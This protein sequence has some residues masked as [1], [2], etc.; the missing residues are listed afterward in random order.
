MRIFINDILVP[1]GNDELNIT[2]KSSLFNEQDGSTIYNFTL[3]ASDEL[4]KACGFVNRL[5]AGRPHEVNFKLQQDSFILIGIGLIIKFGKDVYE[6]QVGFNK[7]DF[8]Y[9][10]KDKKLNDDIFD[11][12][13]INVLYTAKA[14]NTIPLQFNMIYDPGS[15][16][17]SEEIPF[18]TIEIDNNSSFSYLAK[19]Y[20]CNHS[21]KFILLFDF[22]AKANNNN[23]FLSLYINNVYLKSYNFINNEIS[24][25]IMEELNLQLNDT[26]KFLLRHSGQIDT[27]VSVV[28]ESKFTVIE[29]VNDLFFNSNMGYYPTYKHVLSPI[30]NDKYFESIDN[31][32]IKDKYSLLTVQNYF[33][34]GEFPLFVDVKDLNNNILRLSNIFIPGIYVAHILNS[35]A[36]SIG[37][38]IENNI[39]NDSEFSKL[40]LIINKCIN[41]YS[42]TQDTTALIPYDSIKFR[43]Y[44]PDILISDFMNSLSFIAGIVF[45]YKLN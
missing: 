45:F 15:P 39:F 7:G 36:S 3:P 30:Y 14:K 31:N 29:S 11:Y 32:L 33:N 10:I 41:D 25:T 42:Q 9:L 2:M 43:D 35:I 6:L 40:Y 28:K 24:Y 16:A 8:N 17:Q 1:C 20:T 34:N 23:A 21:G 38:T 12:G 26:I 37:Y 19:S 18:N 22:P 13:E 27:L 4:L 5:N 44:I